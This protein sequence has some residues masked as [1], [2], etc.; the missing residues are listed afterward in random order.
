[1]T[2]PAHPLDKRRLWLV[3]FVSIV[4]IV[5]V[6]IVVNRA[7]PSHVASPIAARL[8]AAAIVTVFVRPFASVIFPTSGFAASLFA[9]ATT[10]PA[11]SLV[12][13]RQ[14]PS[15]QNDASVVGRSRSTFASYGSGCSGGSTESSSRRST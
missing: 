9:T 8:A 6:G 1:V 7:S 3:S 2:I 13:P 10:S 4:A 11:K 14:P 5:A 12:A 15:E